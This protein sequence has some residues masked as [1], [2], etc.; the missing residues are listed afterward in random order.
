MADTTV[1]NNAATDKT[2]KSDFYLSN[3]KNS[4][5]QTGN[6][7]LDK[8]AFLKLLVT[9]L[10]NQDPTSPMDDKEFIAQ[11]AQ[12]SS[13]EQMQNVAKSVDTLSEISKQSQLMQYNNFIGKSVNWHELTSEKDEKGNAIVNSGS[14]VVS[15]ISYNGDS[16]IITLED[17]K[18]LTPAN[19]SEVLSG[20]SKK[21]PAN[22]LV[23]ASMLIGKNVS[24]TEENQEIKATVKSVKKTSDGNIVL[25]LSNDKEI[26]ADQL[27]SI[28]E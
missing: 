7:S 4:T 3:K 5:R 16:V 14:G 9:Q 1:I 24:Y 19:I 12:F 20:E 21:N 27:S 2:V 22:S 13:L 8:D 18:K 23:E 15:K 10:Q 6:S 11:M 25:V 28:S 26:Q 17:G